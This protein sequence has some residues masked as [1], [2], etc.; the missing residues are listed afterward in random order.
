MKM[1]KMSQV[2]AECVAEDMNVDEHGDQLVPPEYVAKK[3]H[4]SW[5]V[6]CVPSDHIVELDR[7]EGNYCDD[8]QGP[9]DN[10]SDDYA[11]CEW[12]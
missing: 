6:L 3:F 2:E 5:F 11:E 9:R 7:D 8:G 12:E 10:Y 4:G 1:Y